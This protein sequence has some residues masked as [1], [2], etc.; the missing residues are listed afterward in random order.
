[1]SVGEY[2]GVEGVAAEREENPVPHSSV[3]GGGGVEEEGN[4]VLD[5]RDPVGL[6]VEVGDHGVVCATRGSNTQRGQS[7]R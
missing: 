5:V 6:K 2:V 4:Q 1:M 3:G 7:G